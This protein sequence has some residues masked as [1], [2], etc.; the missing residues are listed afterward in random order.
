MS[1]ELRTPLNAIVGFSEVM[2]GE[3]FGAHVIFPPSRVEGA[4]AEVNASAMGSR[5]AQSPSYKATQAA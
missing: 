4:A 2:K 1:H 5:Q 3:L